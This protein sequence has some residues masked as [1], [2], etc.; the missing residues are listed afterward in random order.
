MQWCHYRSVEGTNVDS[1]P[2]SLA[3]WW[4][5]T[6]TH[7]YPHG[8]E[9]KGRSITYTPW[10]FKAGKQIFPTV[11]NTWMWARY[12]SLS[13][14][15][16]VA[17]FNFRN[18]WLSVWVKIPAWVGGGYVALCSN[19]VHPLRLFSDILWIFTM[20]RLMQF[21]FNLRVFQMFQSQK[22]YHYSKLFG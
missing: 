18:T 8:E 3:E 13:L 19:C 14:C 17:L 6:Y 10:K 11:Y 21:D 5:I 20:L 15:S 22:F 2:P 7:W 12:I 9:A 16:A 4:Y 1:T